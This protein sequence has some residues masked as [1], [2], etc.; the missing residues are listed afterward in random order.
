M[1]Q[2]PRRMN[3]TF[4]MFSLPPYLWFW[5]IFN[6]TYNIA[7]TPTLNFYCLAMMRN[8][9]PDDSLLILCFFFFSGVG[10][11]G[12]SISKKQY[13]V[14]GQSMDHGSNNLGFISSLCGTQWG[15]SI[16]ILW[17]NF[18]VLQ[19]DHVWKYKGLWHLGPAFGASDLVGKAK[20]N[21]TTL[22]SVC[23][24]KDNNS[25]Y[26][27]GLFE[28]W[29]NYYCEDLSTISSTL[30]VISKSELQFTRKR[31]ALLLAFLLGNRSHGEKL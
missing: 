4:T 25:A 14:I 31:I 16:A 2:A 24:N 21:T 8:T 5:H 15:N 13:G 22:W 12:G 17:L 19:L 23:S 28:D 20:L 27:P 10:D 3:L 30:Y 26:L 29:G 9:F 1:C 6:L 11:G 7:P 18:I